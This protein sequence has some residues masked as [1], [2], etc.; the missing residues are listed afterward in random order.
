MAYMATTSVVASP[1]YAQLVTSKARSSRVSLPKARRAVRVRAEAE[2]TVCAPPILS[3]RAAVWSCG[4]NAAGNL[5]QYTTR[6][7]CIRYSRFSGMMLCS[8]SLSM[9]TP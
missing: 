1:K 9:L 3:T 5:H 4:R 8:A 7:I 6:I 2:Q